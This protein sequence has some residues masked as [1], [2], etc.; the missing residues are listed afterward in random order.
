MSRPSATVSRRITVLSSP[1]TTGAAPASG[2]TASRPASISVHWR[3][4]AARPSACRRHP[5]IEQHVATLLGQPGVGGLGGPTTIRPRPGRRIRSASA[6]AT[7]RGRKPSIDPS[8]QSAAGQGDA[9]RNKPRPGAH[10]A[11][12]RSPTRRTTQL[13]TGPGRKTA[14]RRSSRPPNAAS[15]RKTS[16]ARR[17]TA[18]RNNR[19]R[20]RVAPK[21]TAN[22]HSTASTPAAPP[23]IT[24]PQA[25]TKITSDSTFTRGRRVSLD[26]LQIIGFRQ[27]PAG[28][29]RNWRAGARRSQLAPAR[30]K[31]G[32]CP[33]RHAR[34]TRPA[35]PAR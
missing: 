7:R 23:S 10:R 16:G 30:Q 17:N 18:R 26:G 21:R 5:Q 13:G 32:R 8:A 4:R 31:S 11:G 27:H 25:A 20:D 28:R 6:A 12:R 2:S 19:L 1:S 3:S 22:R 35:R 33:T 29:R 15:S 14:R 9:S 24:S 34:R